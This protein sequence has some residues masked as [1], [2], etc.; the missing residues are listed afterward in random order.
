MWYKIHNSTTITIIVAMYEECKNSS[1]TTRNLNF[2]LLMR[3]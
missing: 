1:I 3:L 2:V